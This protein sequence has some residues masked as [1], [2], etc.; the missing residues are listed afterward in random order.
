[1]SPHTQ[2]STGLPIAYKLKNMLYYFLAMS[3][4]TPFIHSDN[5]FLLNLHCG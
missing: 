1:M 5:A 3:L 4:V 2:E